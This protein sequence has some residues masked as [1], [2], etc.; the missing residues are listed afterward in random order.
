MRKI[1]VG[2]HRGAMCH[3][4]ENT[5]AAFDLAVRFGTYRIE[6]DVRRTRDGHLILMHD[7]SVERMTDGAGRVADLALADLKA[8][9]L[10][11]TETIPT[12]DETLAF[13]RGRCRL[14]VEIKDDGITDQVVGEIEVAGMGDACTI[15]AFNEDALLR[16]KQVCPRLATAYFHTEAGAFDPA[17]VAARLG[18]SM[19][20]VWPRAAD[21]EQIAAAKR[22]GLHVRCGLP[23]NITF[24]ETR[25]LFRRLAGMGVDE[26]ACGRPDWIARLVEECAGE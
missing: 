2:A 7:Q 26:I 22:A 11:G 9:R 13:L 15:S 20:V 5:L 1:L 19:L 23:D 10:A 24:E 12:L 6:M 17:E 18:V 8:L 3:A 21:P 14:L 16:V 4:P 25:A